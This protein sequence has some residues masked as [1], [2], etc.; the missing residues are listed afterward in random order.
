VVLQSTLSGLVVPNR[1]V[2]IFSYPLSLNNVLY[3]SWL[4]DCDVRYN[5]SSAFDLNSEHIICVHKIEHERELAE[6]G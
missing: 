4:F 3:Y 1:S 6:T 2:N 5:R